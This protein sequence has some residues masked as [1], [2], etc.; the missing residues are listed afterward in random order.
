MEPTL[1]IFCGAPGCGKSTFAANLVPNIHW[2]SRDAIRFE[3]VKEDEDYFSHEKE[4]FNRFAERIAISLQ[5]GGNTIADAT[6][7]N[8]ASRK[9]LTRAIDSYFELYNIVYIVFTASA[10]LC[11]K[12]NA[13][14][15]GRKKVP[16]DVIRKMRASLTIPHNEDSR[17]IGLITID[18]ELKA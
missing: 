15:S 10:E 16:D 8:T 6:H 4:V 3:L 18:G 1:Y 14:R 17:E 13:N 7:L 12:H 11:I 5:T 2:V 9:K